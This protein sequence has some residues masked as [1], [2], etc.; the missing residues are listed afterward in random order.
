M[1]EADK[2]F[3]VRS[4][5]CLVTNLVSMLK[6]VLRGGEGDTKTTD[7]EIERIARE[8]MK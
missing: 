3:V 6:V 8:F 4:E 1:D 2:E 7:Q 5:P